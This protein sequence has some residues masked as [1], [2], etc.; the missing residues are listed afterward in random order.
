MLMEEARMK[1]WM[2]AGSSAAIRNGTGRS[3]KVY[4]Y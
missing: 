3:L 4:V 2:A 1:I